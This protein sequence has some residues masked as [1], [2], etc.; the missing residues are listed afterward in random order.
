MIE[1]PIWLFVTLLVLVSVLLVVAAAAIVLIV[2]AARIGFKKR[3][4]KTDLLA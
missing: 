1:I 3:N 2:I 4:S